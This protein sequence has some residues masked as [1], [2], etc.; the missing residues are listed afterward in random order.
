VKVTAIRYWLPLLALFAASPALGD[1]EDVAP[2]SRE[3]VQQELYL[4][5]MLITNSP[6]AARSGDDKVKQTLELARTLYTR[7]ND[8]F[9]AGNM[10]WADAFLDEALSVL[11][12]AARLA[13]DPLQTETR[14]RE[15]YAEV[16]DDVRAF[17]ATYQDLRGGLSAKDVKLHDA[18][19][20]R[21]RD[22]IYRAQVMVRDGLYQEATELLERV[23]EV[24][25]SVLNELLAS[26]ALVYDTKFKTPMEEFEYELARY[27]S[28]EELIPIALDQFK[29]D[30]FTLKL[31][32]RYVQD[33][34]TAHGAAE[35]QAAGGD[36]PAAIST[37]QDATKR[38]Q[39]A[40]R[41]I[42]LEV[43]Q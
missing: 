42:G 6:L 24:Y 19:I 10:V 21:T 29:P 22:M 23:H 13:S 30:E 5:K 40:L 32:E 14:Q 28:Y 41:T 16:L 33:G 37:L 34:R 25:I 26:T 1:G 43:P 3:E 4:V 2:P 15:R 12:D 11:E 8:A 38:L 7:G 27:R 17:Q 9:I 39:T 36:H 35:K 20:E 31:S 18:K